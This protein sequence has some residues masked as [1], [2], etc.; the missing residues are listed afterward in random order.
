MMSWQKEAGR[1]ACGK[2][3]L[4]MKFFHLSDLHIG[5]K[6]YNRDL[7]ADQVCVLRQ[8][9]EYAREE[10]PDAVVIAGDLYDRAV[11]S[12]EAVETFDRFVSELTEAVPGTAIMMIS[13]N[14]D[15]APRINCY[16]GLLSRQNLHV[17]GLPPQRPEDHIE[18]VTLRDAF[19][20]VNF[21]LLPFVRPSMV[22]G[23][24]SGDT[25]E[26][27]QNDAPALSGLPAG[28]DIAAAENSA[29]GSG[30]AAALTY[31]E[32]LRRLIAREEI[33]T[34]ERNVLVSHQFYLPAGSAAEDVER[35]DSEVQT[36]GNI[37]AISAEVL[38]PFDYAALGHIHK[39]M[40]VGSAC[41]RYCGTPMPYSVS[42]AGQKKGI[43]VVE[44]GE[45]PRTCS[46]AAGGGAAFTATRVLP[47]VPLHEV[48]ILC[49]TLTEI[50]R[51]SCDD[52]VSVLLT[53]R[54]DLDVLDM[55]DRLRAAFPNLLEIRRESVRGADYAEAAAVPKE[56]DPFALCCSFLGDLDDGEQD[57]LR[58]V[59]RTVQERM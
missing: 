22:R 39:P 3:G 44:M 17:I 25:A 1:R 42:E 40:K 43:V 7:L 33:D 21:W 56:L 41:I 47:L 13:G 24:F 37:D 11:P 31:E 23:V 49:G 30:P 48:R 29:A 58:D 38:S 5:L 28:P 36:V 20:P 12:A 54:V 18:K 45:K 50:L 6:L 34:R 10:Q 59:I 35:M 14:H 51:Q 57:L 4:H 27:Q 2:R 8:I 53:D 9:T 26:R 32:T 15:S 46:T 52:Y 55:Q 19:G 16:R